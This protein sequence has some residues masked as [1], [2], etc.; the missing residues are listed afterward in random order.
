MSEGD[1]VRTRSLAGATKA[2]RRQDLP[3]KNIVGIDERG[4]RCEDTLAGRGNQGTATTGL[5]D[6]P[7]WVGW[8]AVRVDLVTYGVRQ[9]VD[10]DA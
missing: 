9:C 5:T 3:T 2:P 6:H 10:L 1:G 4:R 8:S 7:L